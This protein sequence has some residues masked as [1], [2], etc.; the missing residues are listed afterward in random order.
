MRWSRT[1][2]FATVIGLS[3]ELHMH[4]EVGIVPKCAMISSHGMLLSVLQKRWGMAAPPRG[5]SLG[6]L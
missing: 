1:L 4:I 2:C 6:L 5:V 3:F